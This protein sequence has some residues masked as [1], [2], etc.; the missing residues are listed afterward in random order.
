I[1]EAARA[2]GVLS[3][4]HLLGRV[5]EQQLTS[6]YR[7]SDLF[8]MPNVPIPGDMEGFGVVMLEAGANGLPTVGSDLE[9]IKDVIMPGSNGHLVPTENPEAFRAVVTHYVN[10]RDALNAASLRAE[11]HVLE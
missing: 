8:V 5:S 9:G 6:V 7:G 1:L 10:D 2:N 3:R 4:V 11:R